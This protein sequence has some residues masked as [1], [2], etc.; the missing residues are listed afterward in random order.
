MKRVKVEIIPYGEDNYSYLL[1]SLTDN[2]TALVDCGEALPII[3]YLK[4][5][6][7]S[8]DWIL[9]THH[10]YD[11][12]DGIQELM[13]NFPNAKVVKPK[14]ESRIIFQG[15]EV[16]DSDTIPFGETC[17]K[18]VLVP[19]HTSHSTSFFIEENLFVGDALFSAGCGRIFDGDAHDLELT[20]D[21]FLSF[22]DSTKVYFGHEYTLANLRF[23]QSIEPK[24]RDVLSYIEQLNALSPKQS[25]TTPTTIGL[26][27]KINPF[28]RFDEP[29]LINSFDPKRT[30]TRT[31]RIQRLRRMKDTFKS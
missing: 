18:G 24:N 14:N 23:A 21:R 22:S 30:M 1:Q 3:K 6:Q 8:L 31:E 19:A 5:T 15:I 9:I 26:E 7:R 28:F 12:T 20:M 4:D 13:L 29:E 17:F 25:M 11:H 16:G 10:H 27:K 2:S